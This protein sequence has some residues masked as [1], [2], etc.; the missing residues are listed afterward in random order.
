[1]SIELLKRCPLFAGMKEEDLKKIRAIA[2]PRQAG[3]KEVL[4]GEGQEAKGFYVILS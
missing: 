4:F 2:L 3:K 1:M